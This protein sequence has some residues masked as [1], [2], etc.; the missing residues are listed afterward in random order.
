MVNAKNLIM[1]KRKNI[2]I[3][4]EE[5]GIVYRYVALGNY[6]HGQDGIYRYWPNEGNKKNF[7]DFLGKTDLCIVLFTIGQQANLGYVDFIENIN[8]ELVLK[9]ADKYYEEYDSAICLK[10]PLFLNWECGCSDH[11]LGQTIQIGLN[12]KGVFDNIFIDKTAYEELVKDLNQFIQLF[13]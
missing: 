8:M 10:E 3:E 9:L 13:K 11:R 7:Y 6:E 12:K 1:T 5:S 4:F 2:E